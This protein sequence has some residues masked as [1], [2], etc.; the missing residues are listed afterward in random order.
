MNAKKTRTLSYFTR[1]KN[2]QVYKDQRCTHERYQNQQ[3]AV[4]GNKDEELLCHINKIITAKISQISA[5]NDFTDFCERKVLSDRGKTPKHSHA[6]PKFGNTCRQM[7]S[8][9]SIFIFD[10]DNKYLE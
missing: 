9:I 5:K 4:F 2:R 8:V 10:D 3:Y 6:K 7:Y 1:R